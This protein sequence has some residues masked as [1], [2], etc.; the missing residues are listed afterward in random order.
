M[1]TVEQSRDEREL[2]ERPRYL[3]M[4]AAAP[5]IFI[6]HFVMAY[7]L[8]SVWC[9]K[10]VPTPDGRLGGALVPFAVITLAAIG[11]VAWV[12]WDGYLRHRHQSEPPPHDMDTRGD[13]H[14]FLGFAT[15]LLAGLSGTGIVFVTTAFLAF[16]T[17]R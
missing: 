7:A 1:N 9:A 14:R 16:E 5:A 2:P 10:F 6:T 15:L 8:A 11:G 3:L 4:V 13:R 12:G 17:C